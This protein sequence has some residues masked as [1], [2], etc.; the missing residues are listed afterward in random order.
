MGWGYEIPG[1]RLSEWGSWKSQEALDVDY[2]AHDTAS[3][4][5]ELRESLLFRFCFLPV[6]LTQSPTVNLR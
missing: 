2:V 3:S 1:L 5:L 6:N 4:K